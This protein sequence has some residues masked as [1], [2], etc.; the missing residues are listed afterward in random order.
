MAVTRS[1]E[2]AIKSFYS[3]ADAEPLTAQA[4]RTP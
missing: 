3:G 2:S 1:Y 4:Q